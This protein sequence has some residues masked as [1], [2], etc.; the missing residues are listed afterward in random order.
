MSLKLTD[1]IDI[2]IL[3]ITIRL[4]RT[5]INQQYDSHG[6][7]LFNEEMLRGKFHLKANQWINVDLIQYVHLISEK[8]E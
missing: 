5:V 8:L 7:D 3:L 1:L 2:Y 4:T 6:N